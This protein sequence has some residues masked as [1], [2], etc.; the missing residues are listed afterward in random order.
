MT[1]YQQINA[2]K[3]KSY[4]VMVLFV[5]FIFFL[6]YVFGEASGYGLPV[7]SVALIFSGLFAFGSYYWGDRII[8]SLSQARPADPKLDFDLYTVAENM[9]IAAG[10]PRPK[11]YVIDDSAPNAFA[12]GKDPNHAVICATS[13]LI[14]KLDR[15]ELE[16]VI[17][18]EISHIKNFDIRLM[19][20]V[21]VLVGMVA[22]LSDIFLRSLWYG[23]R[24]RARIRGKMGVIVIL[25]G[26]ILAL[27]S[28][29]I[30]TLIQLAISRQREY[31]AD[32]SAALLTRYPEGLA[33]ALEKISQDKEVL[34]AATNATAH[35]YIVNP[36][37]GKD[38]GA[39]FA[40]LFNTHPPVEERI[41]VLRSM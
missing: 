17:A 37:K 33:R 16:G 15:S 26:F 39:W 4:L 10:I 3:R 32:A 14:A 28:P 19:S 1:I 9:A 30:A 20:I 5:A 12:S 22:F 8:L 24:S 25:V 36:F 38:F 40:G 35:L 41:R 29:I 2:N 34:E 11:L 27:L 21:A 6:G 13:G 31:L 18:H 7:A 23:G